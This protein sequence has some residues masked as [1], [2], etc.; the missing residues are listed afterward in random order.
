MFYYPQTVYPDQGEEINSQ[1][2]DQILKHIDKVLLS[3]G[4]EPPHD[5]L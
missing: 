4:S 3:L 2:S 5:E 1:R